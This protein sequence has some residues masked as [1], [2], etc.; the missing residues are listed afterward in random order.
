MPL[1]SIDGHRGHLLVRIPGDDD[2]MQVPCLRSV[3]R[4]QQ[5]L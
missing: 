5:V 1:L 4:G 2:A 3:F